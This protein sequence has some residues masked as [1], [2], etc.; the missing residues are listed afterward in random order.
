MKQHAQQI[1]ATTSQRAQRSTQQISAT[2]ELD[3]PQTGSE[4]D[5]ETLL[6]ELIGSEATGPHEAAKQA[7]IQ[8]WEGYWK[9]VSPSR[10]NLKTR[11]VAEPDLPR[12]QDP[13]ISANAN[14][15]DLPGS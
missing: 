14:E 9:T 10:Q 13:A 2:T 12:T 7:Y 4:D 6:I 11:S 3:L 5:G 1:S 15:C 8:H